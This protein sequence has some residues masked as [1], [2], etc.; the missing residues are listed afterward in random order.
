MNN[1]KRVTELKPQ[2][3][4]CHACGLKLIQKDTNVWVCPDCKLM[5]W[6]DGEVK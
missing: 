2:P 4:K 6:Y 1:K 5:Y 3:K